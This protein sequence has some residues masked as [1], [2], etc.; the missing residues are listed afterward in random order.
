MIIAID[1]MT[2]QTR[3]LYMPILHLIDCVVTKK[4]EK[5]RTIYCTKRG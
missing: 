1:Y 2:K 3:L 4:K 5:K